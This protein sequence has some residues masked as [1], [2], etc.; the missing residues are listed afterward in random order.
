MP[1]PSSSAGTALPDH[2][3]QPAAAGL[4]LVAV[5]NAVT[6]LVLTEQ[7]RQTTNVMLVVVGAGAVLLSLRWLA[8][9]LYLAWGAWGVG[10]FLVGP[11]EQWAALRR[12][13][14]RRDAARRASS[15]ICAGRTS[16]SSP[17]CAP[18]PTRPRSGTT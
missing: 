11:G 10:A 4:V 14:V 12:R 15:T 3:A 1:S 5:A 16:A 2:L 9:T 17:T 7:P 8:A 18:P 13:H 6:H